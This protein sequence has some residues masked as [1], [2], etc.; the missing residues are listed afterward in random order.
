MTSKKDDAPLRETFC[1]K[2]EK[3]FGSFGEMETSFLEAAVTLHGSGFVWLVEHNNTLSVMKT[4]ASEVPLTTG[5]KP[6]IGIDLWEHAYL[7]D[8]G[9]DR[10]RYVVHFLDKLVDWDFAAENLERRS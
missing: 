2:V 7:P 1:E 4:K 5:R 8:F 9:F 3:D 6:L 10:V